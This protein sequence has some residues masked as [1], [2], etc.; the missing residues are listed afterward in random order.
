MLIEEFFDGG[1]FDYDLLLS[2]ENEMYS[3]DEM[4]SKFELSPHNFCLLNKL[5]EALPTSWLN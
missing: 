3:H 1:L 2:L 5:V 4:A